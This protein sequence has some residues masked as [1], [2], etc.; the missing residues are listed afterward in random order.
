MSFIDFLD[1]FLPN[2][3]ILNVQT[4]MGVSAQIPVVPES[5]VIDLKLEIE[6]ELEV[7]VDDQILL[8]NDMPLDDD[9]RTLE[10]YGIESGNNIQL[11]LKL[12]L[13]F[14]NVNFFHCYII[15]F[16]EVDSS[17]F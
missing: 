16:Q 12:G 6:D 14:K 3:I 5:R 13:F 10:S 1:P 4:M 8:F 9:T 11:V 15:V 7:F 2:E 17:D